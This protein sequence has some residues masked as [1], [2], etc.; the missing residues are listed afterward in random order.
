MVALS[1][2]AVVVEAA[3]RSRALSAVH[4]AQA[5]GRPVFAVPGPVTSACSV[6]CHVLLSSGEARLVT[7][8]ADVLSALTI[9]SA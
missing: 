6:S 4:S 9:R 1:A 8:A 7:G 5:I 3:A 2:G